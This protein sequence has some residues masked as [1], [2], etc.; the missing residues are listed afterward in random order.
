MKAL[1][2]ILIPFDASSHAT[3]AVAYAADVARVYDAAVTI[4]FVDHPLTY[5]LP[6][7][8][9]MT[10]PEQI[11]ELKAAFERELAGARK[12]ALDAGSPRVTTE[13]ERGDPVTEILRYA[14]ENHV[15]LIVMGTHGRRGLT[16]ALLGS[17]AEN[18]VSRAPCPVMTV[19]D[20]ER[21]NER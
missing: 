15:D 7:G 9:A 6:E 20:R 3:E 14:T 5:A 21:E 17:V 18:I 16:R 13:I 2:K 4:L 1:Q 11:A 10:T 12:T 8:Y 19:R